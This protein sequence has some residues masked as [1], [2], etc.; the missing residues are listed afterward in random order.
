MIASGRNAF[1][2]NLRKSSGQKTDMD[3]D[4]KNIL[5]GCVARPPFAATA[6][7]VSGM[8]VSDKARSMEADR[9]GYRC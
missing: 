3:P 8:I 9:C 1:I 2:S 4:A 6:N 5:A 7:G